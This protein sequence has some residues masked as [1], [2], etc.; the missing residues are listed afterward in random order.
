ML[1]GFGLGLNGRQS[2]RKFAAI[3]SCVYNHFNLERHDSR[4]SDF[5]ETR[6]PPLPNAANSRLEIG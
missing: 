4:R 5:K 2:Q 6:T 3:H 1:I